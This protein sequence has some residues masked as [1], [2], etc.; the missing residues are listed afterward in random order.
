MFPGDM[1]G[2]ISRRQKRGPMNLAAHVAELVAS[3][4]AGMGPGL[5]VMAHRFTNIL[6]YFLCSIRFGVRGDSMN[7]NYMSGASD[8]S[9]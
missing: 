2:Q 9:P 4:M 3:G 6:N 1:G 8:G 7:I 5:L